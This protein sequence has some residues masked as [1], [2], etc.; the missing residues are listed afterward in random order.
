MSE[1]LEKAKAALIVAKDLIENTE[2]DHRGELPL[3]V[4]RL[5][6]RLISVA[7]A[8]AQVAQAEAMEGLLTHLTTT[9]KEQE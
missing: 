6:S 7:R 9:R 1:P 4:D 2:L 8:Q 5:I 3:E